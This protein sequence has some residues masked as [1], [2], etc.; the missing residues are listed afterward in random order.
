MKGNQPPVNESIPVPRTFLTKMREL[1]GEEYLSF[2]QSLS[3]P[4]VSGLRI[5]P[6]KIPPAE[7]QIR[8][9][10][11]LVPVPWCPE[12]YSLEQEA[13]IGS[14]RT[15][16]KHPYHA[17]G[18]HYL[19][20]P[21]AMAPVEIL[22]P[23][24]GERVLDLA[25]APGGKTTQIVSRLD[26]TGL[27]VANEIH[28]RRV[29][30][31]AE[32]LERWGAHNTIILN[33]SPARLADSFHLYFDRVLLDAPCSGEGMLRKSASARQDWSIEHVARCAE[34]QSG[35]L[36]QA[37]LLLRPG[38]TTVYST[39]TFSP[40]EN[41]AVIAGFLERHP[42]F[43]LV[44]CPPIPGARPG[45]PDWAGRVPP[46]IA[47]QMDKTIRLW[48]HLLNGDG[49][50][51]ARLQRNGN[52]PLKRPPARRETR[53]APEHLAVFRNFCKAS[54]QPDVRFDLLGVQGTYLYQS[55]SD[56]PDLTGLQVI[57]P[58]WWL[59]TYKQSYGKGT[60]RF[61]PSHAMAL[62]LD[63]RMVKQSISINLSAAVQYLRGEPINAGGMDGWILVC[64]EDFPLGW[65]KRSAETIKNYYPK[66]LRWL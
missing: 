4:Y 40:Q 15:P 6:L 57:H 52:H 64:V 56:S 34:R 35:L 24:P 45:K 5:N 37:V 14:E 44:N 65:G 11:K 21:T 33:E 9:P 26:N 36:D 19:Q 16:G 58:G 62:G 38:G 27:V 47:S 28:P 20:E 54:L 53:I 7:F 49:H 55:I 23:Q 13:D 60:L 22:D 61:E 43:T 50:F 8:F 30:D 25:A 2:H 41:E 39:C 18:L 63:R 46:E 32:N 66:G 48:P 31:L 42:D 59:G 10:P 1:L 12:G 29:W 3:K 51:I 17:A